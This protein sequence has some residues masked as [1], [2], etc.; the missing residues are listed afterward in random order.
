MTVQKQGKQNPAKRKHPNPEPY[1]RVDWSKAA[2]LFQRPLVGNSG[3]TK[4][5][6]ARL[7]LHLLAGAGGAGLTF[8]FEAGHT[9]IFEAIQGDFSYSSWQ[10][11]QMLRQLEKQKYV[12]I[13][14]R[15]DGKTMVTIATHGLSRALTYELD[16]MK[17]IAPKKWDGKWRVVIFDILEEYKHLRDLFRMRIKQL[18]LYQ[19]QESVYLSPTPCFDEVEFLREL[20]GVAV[21]VRYLL[22]D[23][24]EDD[25]FIKERFGLS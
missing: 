15:P 19:L 1:A 20:Y 9:S 17:L 10:T 5:P 18:G 13:T 6:S 14:Q 3:K 2:A 12:K 7:L 4:L 25:K 23:K 21:T 16:T 24:I 11:R 8:I 22:V